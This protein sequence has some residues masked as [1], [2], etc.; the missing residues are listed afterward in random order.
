MLHKNVKPLDSKF[1]LSPT[2]RTAL[3]ES[4]IDRAAAQL[5]SMIAQIEVAKR[6]KNQK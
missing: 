4:K 1:I 5:Q 6:I 2:E 3:L